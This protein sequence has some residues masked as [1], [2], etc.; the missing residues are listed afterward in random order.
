MSVQ[1]IHGDGLLGMAELEEGSVSLIVND[2]PWGATRADWDQPL[3]WREW[4]HPIHR[5]LRPDGVVA[6]FA[7]VRLFCEIMPLATRR[8][9]YDLIW[10]KNRASGHLNAKRAPMRK[11]ESIFIFGDSAR[12]KPRYVPQFT[13]GH[14]PMNAATRHSKSALYGRE[15]VT[16]TEAGTTDRYQTSVLEYDSVPNDS[17]GRIHETQKPV[18]LLEW[19]L[20]AY[21]RPGE[22]VIDPTCGSGSLLHAARHEGRDAIGW[23][24]DDAIFQRAR[25][26]LDGTDSPLFAQGAS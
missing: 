22:L 19:L 3:D 25:A 15:T 9:A 4:W 7:S 21:S 12:G 6:V 18:P 20:R 11:H 23:E 26:W 1:L 14:E 5:C 2:P 16:V 17:V 13:H 24:G 10:K 8:F